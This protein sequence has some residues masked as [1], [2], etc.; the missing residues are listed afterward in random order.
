M[1]FP[2]LN[3]GN[4]IH[5]NGRRGRVLFIRPEGYRIE[6]DAFE[7]PLTL[8]RYAMTVSLQRFI[9]IQRVAAVGPFRIEQQYLKTKIAAVPTYDRSPAD[10]YRKA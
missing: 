1:T 2:L 4:R 3:L 7:D 5:W 9:D 8:E 10:E 6:W